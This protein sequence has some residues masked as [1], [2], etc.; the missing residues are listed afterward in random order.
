MMERLVLTFLLGVS[1]SAAADATVSS[2]RTIYGGDSTTFSLPESKTLVLATKSVENTGITY[3]YYNKRTIESDNCD[4][5]FW[6]P[7]WVPF[8]TITEEWTKR[9]DSE[10]N[11]FYENTGSAE[12]R[13]LSVENRGSSP[14]KLQVITL[15][16]ES[17]DTMP[18]RGAVDFDLPEKEEVWLA[19]WNR[20]ETTASVT[21]N[22]YNY[23]ELTGQ[24]FTA[25]VEKG[26]FIIQIYQHRI[27]YDLNKPGAKGR[28]LKLL[29]DI[30]LE[31]QLFA[32]PLEPT[33][34]AQ[35]EM[36]ARPVARGGVTRPH[37]TEETENPIYGLPRLQKPRR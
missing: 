36:T 8:L 20:Q 23:T 35:M 6:G 33:G 1:L 14:V 3:R 34:P 19:I 21:F 7:Q 9:Y 12:A 26:W 10:R 16:L 29:S 2:I 37:L 28:R 22:W 24:S 17:H 32:M 18:C 27:V 5:C 25:P 30:S 15:P 11:W 4:V 13:N 31:C